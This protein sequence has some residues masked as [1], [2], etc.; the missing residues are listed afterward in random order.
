[1]VVTKKIHT[2]A[3]LRCVRTGIVV[4]MG[5]VVRTHDVGG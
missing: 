1:V 3:P 5:G 4:C 2:L